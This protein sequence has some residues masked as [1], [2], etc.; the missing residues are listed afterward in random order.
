MLEVSK[1]VVE[2]ALQERDREKRHFV[3]NG[4]LTDNGYGKQGY[5]SSDLIY[6]A[7]HTI[8]CYNCSREMR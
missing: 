3:P 4:R 7:R 5:R 6:F 1:S 2:K 8:L